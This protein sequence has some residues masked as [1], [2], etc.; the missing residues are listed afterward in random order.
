MEHC[1][2]HLHGL[3]CEVNAMGE[4]DRLLRKLQEGEDEKE[5]GEARGAHVVDQ[6]AAAASAFAVAA[7]GAS[8]EDPVQRHPHL[9]KASAAVHRLLPGQLQQVCI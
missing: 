3:I 2:S 4:C 8:A 5:A 1:H 6:K 9:S 7:P